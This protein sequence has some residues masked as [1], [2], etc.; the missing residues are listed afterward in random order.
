MSLPFHSLDAALAPSPAPTDLGAL[1]EWRLEDLVRRHGFAALR[2]RSRARRAGGEALRRGL[3]RQA[4]RVRRP[5]GRRRGARRG[6]QGLRGAAGSD[7]ARHVLRVAALRLRHQRLRPC[8]VLWRRAR[9]RDRA[10]RRSPVLRARAQPHRRRQARGGDGDAGA[11]PLP[12]LARGHPQGEAASAS[13]TTSSDCSW[14]S[15]SA[16]APPGTG[17]S[18]TRWRRCGSTSRARA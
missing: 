11:R 7:R 5:A 1:P 8:E 2:R 6:G 14:K 3:S 13:P 18:T 10:R 17:C 9:T 16:A 15:R 4:R 12:P